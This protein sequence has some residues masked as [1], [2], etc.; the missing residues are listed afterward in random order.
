M[1]KVRIKPSSTL[2]SA[3]FVCLFLPGSI[4]SAQQPRSGDSY[5]KPQ[6]SRHFVQLKGI[7]PGAKTQIHGRVTDAKGGPMGGVMV[8]AYDEEQ[9]M[10][11]SVFT[12]ADG[13]FELKELRKTTHQVRMRLPGQLDEWVEDVEPDSDALTVRM[14]PAK[15]EDLQMQRTAASAMS[16]MKWD[17]LRDKENY[18]MMCAYC[19][20]I[21]TVGFRTPEEPVDWETMVRRMDGFGGLY[22]H[23]QKTI[24]KRL[25]NTYTR[26][27][28]SR[29][30]EHVEP[31]PTGFATKMKITEWD[32]G[33]PL[34]AMVHDLEPGPPGIMYLVDMGQ[35]AIVELDITTGRRTVYRMPLKG[36]G[37]HSI[38][39]D[40]DGNY[41]VTLCTS[42]HMGKFD[43][44]TKDITIWSS[45]EIPANRGSYPHTLRVD[46]KDPQGLV[47][48]TDAGRNSVFSIHP[49]SGYVKEYHL[50]EKNQAVAAGKGE[51]RGLTPYGLDVAP[52]GSIWYSKLNANRI[53]RID[54]KA[55]DG[56]IREWN[57]PFRGPRR[58]HVD[59]DGIVWVPGFGSGVLG[60]FD[61]KS[62]Q[63]TTYALPDYENQTPYALNIDAK[64]IIWICGTGN[65]TIGRFDP[66]TERLIEIPM[67]TRVTFTREIEFDEQGN[68]WTCSSNGPTRHNERG[69]GSVIRI[70]LPEGEPAADEGVKLEQIVL[71][72]H[73]VAFVRQVPWHKSPHGELLKKIDAMPAPKG[74]PVNKTLD[75]HFKKRIASFT[76][77]QRGRFNTLR[78]GMDLVDPDME[79]RGLSYLK[80]LEYIHH[81]EK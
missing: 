74:I 24:V 31:L 64:G 18:K 32:I 45:A 70:E 10:H 47:W 60:R 49:K 50:L 36:R 7:K 25:I 78:K 2:L 52:D 69:R 68:V 65:D 30:P 66:K 5:G 19:H 73:Q 4:T 15:G 26:D 77:K 39:P 13:N 20:Q 55:P 1:N 22:K 40:N 42:G 21:G 63:W 80:I 9:Q 51:S 3:A 27:A 76:D 61:P 48:Y 75:K 29:W 8:S 28:E 59:Q 6:S 46:P 35:N 14:E 72:H 71:P 17:S 33:I 44:K 38:E 11:V 12:A 43:P 57:P 37:P 54:P 81:N 34:K 23:T 62:E 16:L 56:D 67:P 41:W 53:G 79:N 58:H